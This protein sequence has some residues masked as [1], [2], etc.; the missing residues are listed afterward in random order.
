MG[1]AALLVRL[2]ANYTSL[3]DCLVGAAGGIRRT[4][5]VQAIQAYG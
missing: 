1:T 2:A 5:T 4:T 3:P